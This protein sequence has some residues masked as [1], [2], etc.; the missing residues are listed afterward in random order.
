MHV[1]CLVP[2]RRSC[3]AVPLWYCFV[4][5]VLHYTASAGWL[6]PAAATDR[7]GVAGTACADGRTT[8][9]Q[10]A[11]WDLHRQQGVSISLPCP[12]PACCKPLCVYCTA[13]SATVV[14]WLLQWCHVISLGRLEFAKHCCYISS[15]RVLLTGHAFTILY[16]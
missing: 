16:I 13:G 2:Q 4:S 7:P 10:H 5:L 12:E 1:G 6:P 9:A 15:A 14:V 3:C 11:N 8:P